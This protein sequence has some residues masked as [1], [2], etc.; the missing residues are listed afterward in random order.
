MFLAIV[1]LAASVTAVFA[2]GA[3]LAEWLF[4]R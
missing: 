3:L 4:F 1:V 2:G